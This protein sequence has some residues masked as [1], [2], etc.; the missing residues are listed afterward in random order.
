MQRAKGSSRIVIALIAVACSLVL[1]G[2]FDVEQKIVLKKDLSGTAEFKMGIDFEPMVLIMT[3]MQRE[4]GGKTGEPTKAELDAARQKFLDEMKKEGPPDL[5]AEIEKANKEMPEGIKMLDA[6]AKQDG[7]KMQTGFVFSFDDV[8]KLNQVAMPKEKKEGEEGGPPAPGSGP[9]VD[10]PF[11]GLNVQ[12]DG[13][14]VLITSKPLN[15]TEEVKEQAPPSE[16][17][18]LDKQMENAFKS[19]RVAYR[20]E[21]DLEVVESNA[22]RKEGNALIW[23]W[24]WEDFKAMEKSGAKDVGVRVRYKK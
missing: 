13:K 16:D 11:E 2:C 8:K 4:M 14:T 18:K 24:K 17:G 12:D 6:T 19:M 10:K 9:G 5:K 22:K 23:E 15:P 3:A 20:I 7:L 1:A 21:S